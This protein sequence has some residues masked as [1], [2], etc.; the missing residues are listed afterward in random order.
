MGRRRRGRCFGRSGFGVDCGDLAEPTRSQRCLPNNQPRIFSFDA[1]GN[2]VETI[3]DVDLRPFGTPIVRVGDN[4]GGLT[5]RAETGQLAPGLDRYSA[6]L[7]A[8]LDV[9][10]GFTPF[11]EAK[12]VH[13]DAV[14]EGGPSFWRDSITGFFFGERIFPAEPS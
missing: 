12:F 10:D 5:T 4:P 2:L 8:H 13:I 6:N 9:S 11:I 14:Q 1:N 7:L 3:P